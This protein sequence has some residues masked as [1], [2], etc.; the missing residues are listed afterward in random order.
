M[1]KLDPH[2]LLSAL[3]LFILLNIMGWLAPGWAMAS[4]SALKDWP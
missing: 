4:G 3:W 2:T 1:R